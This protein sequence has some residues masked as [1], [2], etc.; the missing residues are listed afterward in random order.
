MLL[1]AT[2]HLLYVFCFSH[3]HFKLN[4]LDISYVRFHDP[5]NVQE[6]YNQL[7]LGESGSDNNEST[8]PD[9]VVVPEKKRKRWSLKRKNL[10][11][12]TLQT[13]VVLIHT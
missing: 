7:G 12:G 6:L 11:N 1:K 2:Q 13:S 8:S 5:S 3:P 4:A 10:E 9:T